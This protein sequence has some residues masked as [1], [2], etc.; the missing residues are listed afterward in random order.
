MNHTPTTSGPHHEVHD[1]PRAFPAISVRRRLPSAHF[2][3]FASHSTVVNLKGMEPRNRSLICWQMSNIAGEHVDVV[4]LPQRFQSNRRQRNEAPI[5]QVVYRSA[6]WIYVSRAHHQPRQEIARRFLNNI[7][8]LGKARLSLPQRGLE[9]APNYQ[10]RDRGRHQEYGL[11]V[12]P[13]SRVSLRADSSRPA[14]ASLASDRT[15]SAWPLIEPRSV[16]STS[17]TSMDPD[18]CEHQKAGYLRSPSFKYAE[19]TTHMMRSRPNPAGQSVS[20]FQKHAGIGGD[21]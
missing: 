12:L 10:S 14:N 15:G 8:H 13:E 2:N 6:F 7:V 11:P 18:Y 5:P 20:E 9:T 17:E 16:D 19:S 21:A 4:S 3:E 1:R